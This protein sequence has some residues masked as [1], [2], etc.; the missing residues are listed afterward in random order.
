MKWEAK[1]S[2]KKRRG[3]ESN[4]ESRRGKDRKDRGRGK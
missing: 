1:K 3:Q 2:G 4:E